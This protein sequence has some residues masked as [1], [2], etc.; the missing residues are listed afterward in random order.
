M[1]LTSNDLIRNFKMQKLE[2][3][4][5]F[6]SRQSESL[7]R[8]E[9]PF[10]PNGETVNRSLMT[11]IYYLV[12]NE[13]FSAFHKLKGCETYHF[14]SGARLELTLIYPDGQIEVSILGNDLE[15]GDIPQKAVDGGVWQASRIAPGETLDWSF[16]G[17]TCSPGFEFQDYKNGHRAGLIVEFPEHAEV[18]RALTR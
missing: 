11:S 5:G 18:I 16:I 14:Y 10:G 13:S 6:F 4:G 8:V 15:A 7:L 17:T 1:H 12:T 3:E 9:V 2:P